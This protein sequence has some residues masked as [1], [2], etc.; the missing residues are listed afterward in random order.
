MDV[1]IWASE[2]II[3]LLYALAYSSIPIFYVK[4]NG[5]NTIIYWFFILCYAPNMSLSKWKCN[6]LL[7]WKNGFVS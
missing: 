4:L 5:S 2:L 6:C 3:S 7:Q 1:C